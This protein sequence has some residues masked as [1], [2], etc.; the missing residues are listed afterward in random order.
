M[1]THTVFTALIGNY[2]ELKTPT[3]ITPGWRYICFTDQVITNPVWEIRQINV[4]L[5]PQ[6]MARYIKI[7]FHKFVFSEYSLWLDASFRI[8]CNLQDFWNRHFKA[9]ISAPQHPQRDC[10][11]REISSCLFNRRGEPEILAAQEQHYRK[12]GVEPFKGIITSGVLMR[13]KTPWTV[14]ICEKWWEE[15]SQ[16]STRDQI[17]FYKVTQGYKIPMFKWDY[18]NNKELKY[19]HHFKHRH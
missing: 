16:W 1:T 10:V 17:A 3:V 9:P 13:Q 2:E 12:I 6:R 15:L 11:Y 7:N 19:F 4:D 8:D 5:P 18:S 14:D